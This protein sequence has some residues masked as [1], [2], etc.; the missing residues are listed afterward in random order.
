MIQISHLV[1]SFNTKSNV[2]NDISLSLQR[3]GLTA[4]VGA[5]GCGKTTLL[6]C[7]S[8]LLKYNGSINIDGTLIECLNE[9]QLD[10]FRLRNIGFVFQDFKLYNNETVYHNIILPL[11]I[12]S[13]ASKSKKHR[14]CKDLI[15]LVGL[16]RN[17][18]AICNVLSGGEKQRVAIARSL[19]NDPKIILADEPTG[20]LDENNS[21]AIM[22][23]LKKVSKKA[24]VIIVTHDV[25]LV[26]RYADEIIHMSDGE[27]VK[28]E[29]LTRNINKVS[30]PIVKNEYSNKK[31]LIP[32]EFLFH[33]TLSA[34]KVKKWRTLF[35]NLIT[36]LGL[37]GVG[38]STIV[39]SSISTS[40]KKSYSTIVD[41]NKIFM[42]IKEESNPKYNRYAGSEEEAN[43]ILKR[44]DKYLLDLG[45]CYKNDIDNF[46]V[47]NHHFS[48]VLPG[49]KY[50]FNNLTAQQIND[51]KWLDYST[52]SFFPNK[53]AQLNNDELV[54]GLDLKTIENICYQLRI[55]RTVNSLST[56]LKDNA[57]SLC[58]TVSNNL[59]GYYDEEIFTVRAFSLQKENAIYHSNHIFN[60]FIFEDT[61]QLKTSDS[62]YETDFYPWTLKKLNYFYSKN[63]EQFLKIT[64]SEEDLT[65]FL[66][67]IANEDYFP[68]LFIN[69]ENEV[70]SRLL[71]FMN[72]NKE[73]PP[74]FDSYYLKASKYISTPLFGTSKGY[75]L[76][77]ENLMMGFYN[78][79]FFSFDQNGIDDAIDINSSMSLETGQKTILPDN[80]LSGHFTKTKQNGTIFIPIDSVSSYKGI[81]P[82]SYD[83]IVISR[84]F[85]KSLNVSISDIINKELYVACVDSEVRINENQVYRDFQKIVLKVVGVT[86]DDYNAIYHDSFWSILFFQ[87][88]L[89]ISVFDLLVD[90]ISF[91]LIDKSKTKSVMNELKRSFPYLDIINPL[92]DIYDSVNNI[93]N[94][95][96]IVLLIFSMLSTVISVLLLSICNYLHIVENAKDIALAR[97]LGAS[98]NNAKKFLYSHSIILTFSSF[99]M[100]S[101]ELLFVSIVLSKVLS[102]TLSVSNNFSFNPLAL[103]YMFVLALVVSLFSSFI[104]SNKI[105]KLD[106]LTYLAH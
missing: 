43:D 59:W 48:L 40:I 41:D 66:F 91:D 6:N 70:R 64:K 27:I 16:K 98:K 11:E 95:V 92:V 89:H 53:P 63:V 56:F 84:G 80:V 1:K 65:P 76:F 69:D 17:E 34:I 105:S 45:V 77:P 23:L 55:S 24:L 102:S 47:D 83:D 49:Q 14:K 68:S 51:F 26:S 3:N 2:I 106:P 79:T 30:L 75:C 54:L 62:L 81:I 67:E 72:N 10:N 38:L 19:V 15:D 93:C 13:N 8:G 88:K 7:I 101:F 25:D 82:A 12:L 29:I 85:A 50:T 52:D 31:Q 5:S 96:Q 78:E 99:I 71:F 58:L 22:E 90:T 35:C 18:T 61:L 44:Y 32:G 20:S 39:S 42:R 57:F 74:Q 28:Q 86:D 60:K 87:Y 97:C 104:I 21:L 94:Y 4:I 100:S 33:H 73:I 37:I 103:I 46:F 9:K 36:S